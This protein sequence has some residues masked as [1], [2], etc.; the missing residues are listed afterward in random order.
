[1][2]LS[3]SLIYQNHKFHRI[4]YLKKNSKDSED[5]KLFHFLKTSNKLDFVS[6]V[7]LLSI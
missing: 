3:I 2:I 7:S 6:F 1:M 5:Q 4:L